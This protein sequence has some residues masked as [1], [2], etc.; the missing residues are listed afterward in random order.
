MYNNSVRT[1]SCNVTVETGG[2]FDNYGTITGGTFKGK[3]TGNGTLAGG[4]FSGAD[5][6]G[7][8][9]EITG[10]TFTNS[11]IFM[12]VEAGGKISGGTFACMVHNEGA[13]SGG[14]V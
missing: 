6:S 4:D 5:L 13:I 14:H 2:S 12:K 3:I 11:S 8:D 10:G 9:G 7:F 1:L